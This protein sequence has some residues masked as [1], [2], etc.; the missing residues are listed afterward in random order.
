MSFPPDTPS[1]AGEGRRRPA[2]VRLGREFPGEAA[3]RPSCPLAHQERG[4]P[5]CG[6]HIHGAGQARKP[7]HN[8]PD[9]GHKP[10]T[11]GAVGAAHGQREGEEKLRFFAGAD[12]VRKDVALE[13]LDVAE[14]DAPRRISFGDV[15]RLQ[16]D[17][18]PD[19]I[20]SREDAELLL[21]LALTVAAPTAPLVTG[22]WP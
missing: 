13:P 1:G 4:E 12:P 5:H 9:H 16:R 7:D 14:A 17:I 11:K 19:G 18:L 6:L 20:S 10:V 21:T 8:I 22:L 3:H 15:K 2:L